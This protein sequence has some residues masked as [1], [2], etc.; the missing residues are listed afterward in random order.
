MATDLQETAM[1]SLSRSDPED[2]SERLETSSRASDVS[3]LQESP[4]ET[5]H[6]AVSRNGIPP[7]RLST[8]T[9]RKPAAAS[10]AASRLTSSSASVAGTGLSK[11]PTRPLPSSASRR[12]AP[13]VA[14]GTASNSAHK[15]R[16]SISSVDSKR[17]GDESATED[18]VKASTN[19]LENRPLKTDLKK[20]S[21][22]STSHRTS[23]SSSSSMGKTAASARQN[24]DSPTKTALRPTTNS[25]RPNLASSSSQGTRPIASSTRGVSSA[26][27]FELRK[28]RLSTIP[29]S[30]APRRPKSVSSGPPLSTQ[31][32]TASARPH[33]GTRK[34]TMSISLEQ[35]LREM[36]VVHTMLQVAMAEDGDSTDEAKE[37]YG[38]KVDES[39]AAIRTKLEEARRSQGLDTGDSNNE[40]ATETP[41]AAPLGIETEVSLDEFN[42][43]KSGLIESQSKVRLTHFR[44][45]LCERL[46]SDYFKILGGII[47]CG[48]GGSRVESLAA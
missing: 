7:K 40:A 13:G 48:T 15:K 35:S 3:R 41:K 20:T 22:S 27:A 18:T 11:P 46:S 38:K 32:P 6:H 5:G 31:T 19:L 17:K 39:L 34:S 44:Q 47:E 14:V 28:K 29:A 23:L 10:T 8:I 21:L 42:E 37:E 2:T 30:P 36:E 9:N 25:L 12:T 16:A 45:C 4:L 1:E 24:T 33:L 43:L 26:S